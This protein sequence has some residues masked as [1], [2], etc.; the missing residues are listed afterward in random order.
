MTPDRKACC[1]RRMKTPLLRTDGTGFSPS[2]ASSLPGRAGRLAGMVLL[3]VLLLMAGCD[4]KPKSVTTALP[5]IDTGADP[6]QEPLANQ[7]KIRLKL[8]AGFVDLVPVARYRIAAVVASKLKYDDGWG[9]EVMPFDLALVWGRLTDPEVAKHLVIKHDNTRLAWFRFR[10]DSPPV[11]LQYV[12]S[13]GSNNH[14]IPANGNLFRALDRDLRVRDRVV[15]EGYLVNG[16]GLS[17]GRTI[18]LKTSLSRDDSDRGACEVF[19]VTSLRV[20]ERLYR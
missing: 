19:Y 18:R 20:E 4:E 8:K 1:P 16:E 14:V 12:L 2:P 10:G 17:E 3:L 6:V 15:L 13:H 7:A 5:P 11:S 9:A